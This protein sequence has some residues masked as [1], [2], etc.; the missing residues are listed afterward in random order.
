M[1]RP[2]AFAILL[3]GLMHALTLHPA[4]DHG[5]ATH[6]RQQDHAAHRLLVVSEG[7]SELGPGKEVA[8]SL[9]RHIPEVH[10]Q[11]LAI[12]ALLS[13][14]SQPPGGDALT[15]SSALSIL[16]RFQL[17]L[18]TTEHVRHILC[19]ATPSLSERI[20]RLDHFDNS[21]AAE[22]RLQVASSV[23]GGA[24]SDAWIRHWSMC[25]SQLTSLRSTQR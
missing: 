4:N 24:S 9:A 18:A 3:V 22:S 17:I 13:F 8:E 11:H 19:A 1:R 21:P 12:E 7:D 10:V 25:V 16:N 15:I 14:A 6:V 23:G 5:A 2:R 20:Y